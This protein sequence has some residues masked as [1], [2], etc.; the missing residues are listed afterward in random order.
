M[1][2]F[3]MDGGRYDAPDYRNRHLTL[4]ALDDDCVQPESLF[5]RSALQ[6]NATIKCIGIA[7]EVLD[8]FIQMST[9]ALQKASNVMYVRAIYALVALMK[10]DYAVGTD[11]EGMGEVILSQDLKV[12]YYLNTVIQRTTEA[13]GPQKCRVPSHWLFA[14]KHKL[15][16]WHDEHQAWRNEGRHL[17]RVRQQHDGQKET[18]TSAGNASTEAF[19]GPA[20]QEAAP[21]QHIPR[22]S[23]T[24]IEQAP[25]QVSNFGIGNPFTPWPSSRISLPGGDTQGL[26]RRSLFPPEMG[27]FSAAFQNGDLYLWNDVNDNLGGWIPQ[28]GSIYSDMQFGVFDGPGM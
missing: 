24:D 8:C 21:A 9:A 5:G 20:V 17:K 10:A 15:K 26:Q 13:I 28:S 2:E 22:S 18:S 11:V 23:P 6:L 27:D 14:L 16:A 25:T 1:Y 4:P 3:A 7:Q 12:D 19:G